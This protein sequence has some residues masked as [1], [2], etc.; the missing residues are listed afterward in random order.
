MDN[1][2]KCKCKTITFTIE[3]IGRNL[4]DLGF[5]NEFLDITLKKVISREKTDKFNLTEIKNILGMCVC[6]KTLMRLKRQARN[7]EKIFVKH[8]SDKVLVSHIHK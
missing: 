3:N 8:I 6:V 7:Q 4:Y 5:V 1:R 2:H